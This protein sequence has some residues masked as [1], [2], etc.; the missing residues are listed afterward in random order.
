MASPKKHDMVSPGSWTSCGSS[1]A[2]PLRTGP[3]VGGIS[4]RGFVD[5]WSDSDPG[6]KS[7]P[8]ERKGWFL[9]SFQDK[10]MFL[11]IEDIEDEF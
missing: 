5:F 1:R 2:S 11:L 10:M 3:S 8:R 4:G 9:W 6:D 7:D